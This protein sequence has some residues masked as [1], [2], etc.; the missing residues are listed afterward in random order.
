MKYGIDINNERIF[1]DI[2]EGLKNKGN[3]IV[4]LTENR[5]TTGR[6]LLKKVLIANVTNIDFYFAIDFKNEISRCEIFYDEYSASKVCAEKLTNILSR[7]FPNISCEKG[8][9][10]YLVKNINAAVLYIRLPAGD[11]DKFEKMVLENLI[12]ILDSIEL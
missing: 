7:K 5:I 4:D 12:N 3:F 6:T 8:E 2:S 9:Y 10:L 11:E 1:N